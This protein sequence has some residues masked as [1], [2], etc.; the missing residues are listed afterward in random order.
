MRYM[1]VNTDNFGSD[2]PNE[3]FL[4]IGSLGS[5]AD[6]QQ[7]CNILNREGGD[8]ASRYYKVVEYGYTLQPGFE[9]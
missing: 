3:S 4:P 5:Q 9:P 7:I 2:Y 1:I 8:Y 6:A